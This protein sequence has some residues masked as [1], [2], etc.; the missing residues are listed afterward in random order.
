MFPRPSSMRPSLN[1]VFSTEILAICPADVIFPVT[2]RSPEIFK[3]P[4]AL[5]FAPERPDKVIGI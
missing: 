3:S 5:G 4:P 1:T 2:T